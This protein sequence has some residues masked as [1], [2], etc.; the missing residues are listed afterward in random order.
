MKTLPI[1]I[2]FSAFLVLC[3][4]SCNSCNQQPKE[5]KTEAEE[6]QAVFPDKYQQDNA[7]LKVDTTD[8]GM[9]S[10]PGNVIDYDEMVEKQ[11]A[12]AEKFQPILE[13]NGMFSDQTHVTIPVGQFK[14]YLAY[15]EQEFAKEGFR[16]DDN[17]E[18]AIFFGI[19][20]PQ[21]EYKQETLTVFIF[22]KEDEFFKKAE[23]AGG[24][25]EG[26]I[27]N[28]TIKPFY[29]SAGVLNRGGVGTGNTR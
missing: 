23:A 3:L 7:F 15:V 26:S 8:T 5:A 18:M 12:F 29:S 11:I 9:V 21:G 19:N 2:L 13:K 24:M 17:S 27:F 1:R 28:L 4:T 25:Q 22:P 6:P 20:P 14:K 16:F 10:R